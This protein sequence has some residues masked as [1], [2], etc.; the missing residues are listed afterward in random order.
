MK[1]LTSILKDPSHFRVVQFLV[2]SSV[3][4]EDLSLSKPSA[5]FFHNHL[6]LDMALGAKLWEGEY[7]LGNNHYEILF[8]WMPPQVL[9]S[10]CVLELSNSVTTSYVWCN[11]KYGWCNQGKKKFITEEIDF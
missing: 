11:L 4:Y 3:V 2:C 8:P 6:K 9:R 7:Y 1:T 10:H 5:L